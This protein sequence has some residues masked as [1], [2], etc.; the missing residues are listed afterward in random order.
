MLGLCKHGLPCSHIVPTCMPGPESFQHW[1]NLS[2][3]FDSM[4]RIGLELNRGKSGESV[5]WQVVDETLS[6]PDYP[7]WGELARSVI[8]IHANIARSNY[9]T[10]MRRLVYMA[11]IRPR[12]HWNR[13]IW[14]IDMDAEGTNLAAILTSQLML[15]VAS[16]KAQIKCSECP[17]WFIPKRNQRKYCD[18]C[19]IKAAWRVAQRRKRKGIA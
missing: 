11:D 7:P 14:N 10:L 13:E 2:L 5:D 1:K 3:C 12:F 16:S 17:R 15:R 9:M 8:L 18:H 6:L 19:G 4:L